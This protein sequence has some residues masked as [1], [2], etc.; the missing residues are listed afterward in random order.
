MSIYD[1]SGKT[2]LVTGAETG[3][4]RAIALRALA[5]GA[6]VAGAGINE[7]G[8]A[9][10]AGL[11]QEAGTADRFLSLT[12]D[13]RD[14]D[15][16]N[17]MV[18]DTVAKFGRLDACVANAG[19][20][21]ERRPFVESTHEEW[22][23]VLSVNLHGT[24]FTLQAA[25]RVLRRQGEGGDL[26]VTTSS[27]AVRPGPQASSYVASKSALHQ[28]VRA[29]AVELGPEKIRVNAIV[30]GLTLT[31]GTISRP[32][33][34]DRGLKGIPMGEI[35]MPEEVAAI[36]AFTLSGEAPH[37]TGTELKV[38]GGRTSA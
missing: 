37:L 14:V 22:H 31:P 32:G 12:V 13:I 15:R 34:I 1:L 20:M 24:F 19:V 38:D 33:H 8:L 3:I 9:E 2:V 23:H 21:I 36:V 35:T 25:T 10:T 6:N 7:E 30:P 18:D 26:L 28:M 27:N 29:L 17:A 5:D 16:V 4:G 11:A